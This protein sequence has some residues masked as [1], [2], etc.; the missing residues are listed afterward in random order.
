MIAQVKD[1]AYWVSEINKTQ[2]YLSQ[3]IHGDLA[4]IKTTKSADDAVTLQD[5][6]KEIEKCRQYIRYCEA[7]LEKALEQEEGKKSKPKSLLYF[8]REYGY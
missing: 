4:G 8:N 5:I 6:D 7:E 3:L 2:T 1:S